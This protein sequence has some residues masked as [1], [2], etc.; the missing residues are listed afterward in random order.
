MDDQCPA[1]ITRL[2]VQR[3]ESDADGGLAYLEG[4]TPLYP[5]DG[6]LLFL[7]GS[8]LASL[9]RYAEAERAITQAVDLAPG[10]HVARLQL[11]LLRLTQG[12]ADGASRTLRP[13]E[14]LA[15]DDVYRL[16]ASGL[17]HFMRDEWASA[18][19]MLGKGLARSSGNP[20]LDGN[21]RLLLDKAVAFRDGGAP[22]VGS[23]AQ[24]LLTGA[25][26]H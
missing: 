8:C 26:R 10:F 17:Q 14:E 25:T 22:Q 15:T 24:T 1:D 3:M 16:F 5:K 4:V 19:E 11:G 12:D 9:R 13:L 7:Y 2:A 23:A 21:M 20:P 18:S 6:E